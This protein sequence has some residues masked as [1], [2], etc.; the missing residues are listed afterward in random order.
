MARLIRADVRCV[1]VAGQPLKG[2]MSNVTTWGAW[3]L[4][5]GV[6]V[7]RP[8]PDD[9]D[10]ERS[11][12]LAVPEDVAPRRSWVWEPVSSLLAGVRTAGLGPGGRLVWIVAGEDEVGRAGLAAVWSTEYLADV[13]G[14][15]DVFDD[16]PAGTAEQ[17]A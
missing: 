9:S 15:V 8:D 5:S 17:A 12:G 4:R 10:S 2:V 13:S 3:A 11:A 16:C 6:S 1:A 7:N 14:S